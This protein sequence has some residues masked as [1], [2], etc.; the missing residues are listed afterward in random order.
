MSAAAICT[1]PDFYKAAVASSG[2][3]DNNIY[4]QAWGETHH[5]VTQTVK[6]KDTIFSCKIPTSGELA[7]RLKGHLLVITGDE[8][9]NVHPGQSLRL[10]SALIDA[11]K[12]FEMYVLPGQA[13]LYK[14][15]K[16]LFWR[17]KIWYYFAKYLLNDNRADYYTDIDDYKN[18]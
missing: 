14:G 4:N 3:H 13:H 16:D 11:G 2:N 10:V 8:D 12:N 5:G 7:P 9:N 15:K 18:E 1:Y 6:G 17:Y